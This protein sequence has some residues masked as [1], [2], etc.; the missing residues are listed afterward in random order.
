MFLNERSAL[1]PVGIGRGSG[2][3]YLIGVQS[4]GHG[5]GGDDV[6]HDALAQR[7]GHLVQFHEFAHVVQHVVVLGRR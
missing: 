4:L 5:P 1:A 2:I 6:V 3:R 7:L